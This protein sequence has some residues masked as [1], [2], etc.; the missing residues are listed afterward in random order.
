MSENLTNGLIL[1]LAVFMGCAYYVAM[2]PVN[3]RVAHESHIP[4]FNALFSAAGF[5]L[6]AAYSL[7]AKAGLRLPPSGIAAAACYGI[8]AT[9]A[10]YANMKALERGP[11]SLTSLFAKFSLLLPL[12]Y[13]FL[14]LREQASAFRITGIA[15]I[16]VCIVLFAN[17]RRTGREPLTRGWLVMALLLMVC[18]GA[19][20]LVGKIYAMRSANAYRDAFLL[21]S[22][23]FETLAALIIFLLLSRGKSAGLARA[24]VS[25]AVL[26]LSAVIAVAA[27]VMNFAIVALATRMDGSVFFPVYS[28][29]P[30]ILIALAGYLI[31]GEEM[32]LRK[33]AGILLGIAAIVLLNL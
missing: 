2:K 5:L 13:S 9:L 14:F 22:F 27:L 6:L 29:G 18:N 8:V 12:A 21:W 24:F 30:L 15:L 32:T 7:T 20:Q 25:P 26:G 17:P 23:G 28:G 31:F 1:A 3:M 11:L 10:V 16:F 4:L 19:V 33:A